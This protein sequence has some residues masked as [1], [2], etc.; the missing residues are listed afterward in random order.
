M[1]RDPER[2]TRR[3]GE[4][5]VHDEGLQCALKGGRESLGWLGETAFSWENYQLQTGVFKK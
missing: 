3:G 2:E 4:G 5:D 1:G